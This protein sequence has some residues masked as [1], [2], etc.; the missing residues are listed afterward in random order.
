MAD[1]D[2]HSIEKK[3][4]ALRKS[5]YSSLPAKIRH[6]SELW[7]DV[8]LGGADFETLK[9]LQLVT[10]TLAGSGATFG[11][12]T[13]SRLTRSMD[14]ILEVLVE[15]ERQP[16]ETEKNDMDDLVSQLERESVAVI[17]EDAGVELQQ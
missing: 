6:I 14:E 8:M 10:H 15:L 5:Y 3:L 4:T 17:A 2:K 11:A 1:T 12:V 13:I 7:N 16:D 9:A